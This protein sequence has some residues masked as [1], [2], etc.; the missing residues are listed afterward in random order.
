ME[1]FVP[2]LEVPSSAYRI[3]KDAVDPVALLVELVVVEFVADEEKDE[4]AE[5]NPHRQAK[6]VDQS[7]P[8][9]LAQ[10]AKGDFQV[11]L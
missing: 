10:I 4:R 3:I 11:I 6:D 7:I 8:R 5:R 2:L 1:W 9:L